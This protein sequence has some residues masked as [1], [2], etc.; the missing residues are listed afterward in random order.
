M[1][2]RNSVIAAMLAAG[3]VLSGVAGGESRLQISHAQE[4]EFIVD[5]DGV[6]YTV[7]GN[8]AT[9][10]VV[11]E[12]GS[13]DADNKLSNSSSTENTG[14]SDA[15]KKSSADNTTEDA[16]SNVASTGDTVEI[17]S[18]DDVADGESEQTPADAD[19]KEGSSSAGSNAGDTS[20]AETST[21]NYNVKV[22]NAGS[23]DETSDS[24]SAEDTSNVALDNSSAGGSSDEASDSSS[25]GDTSKNALPEAPTTTASADNSAS[26]ASSGDS[27]DS[28][29]SNASSGDS[30]Q[31][32][33]AEASSTESSA[34]NAAQ[35]DA[36]G[37]IEDGYEM[38]DP[39][40]SYDA[41]KP[42]VKLES[43]S[44]IKLY[45]GQPLV[46][47]MQVLLV[48]E[49]WLDGDGATYTFTESQTEIGSIPN[50]FK[51]KLNPGTPEDKYNIIVKYGELRVVENFN[52]Q[53]YILSIAGK[54]E[55][56]KYDGKKHTLKGFVLSARGNDEYR[57]EGK[58]EP[59]ETLS[60][61]IG[62]AT[63]TVSGINA[64]GSGTN[65]GDYVVDITGSPI[66]KDATGKDV[67][68]DFK[69]EYLP[70]TL[71]IEKRNITMKSVNAKK[72][73]DGEALTAH[74][75]K[76]SG[77]GFVDGEGA[78]YKFT[79]KQKDVGESFNYFTYTMNDGTLEANYNIKKVP[80]KLT[81]NEAKNS[82][83]EN[84][85]GNNSSE[86]NGN[87]EGGSS[88]SSSESSSGS[89]ESGSANAGST[90]PS[91]NSGAGVSAQ[92]GNTNANP[93]GPA[94]LGARK[95][96]DGEQDSKQDA[97]A[98]LGARKAATD[99]TSA[100]NAMRVLIM[101]LSSITVLYITGKN[102]RKNNG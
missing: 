64:E 19:N 43:M 48:E 97:P 71:T 38:A 27:S 51:I 37:D 35:T 77:D 17:P 75:V 9:D 86:E 21:D 91:D 16:A 30:T 60:F 102:K 12:A 74:E 57:V 20:S 66:V 31:N 32:S 25:A 88:G 34:D 58:G 79:G 1:R 83:G 80:G 18:S 55:S 8:N 54:T 52:D 36:S 67:T 69:F 101:L 41:T 15:D 44:Y 23:T 87:G 13:D 61:T 39:S 42:T 93:D 73:Y 76:V 95:S 53:K 99:D 85:S 70:G 56:V 10:D 6:S 96:R 100:D 45:D 49:G 7:K 98:V 90:T 82:G 2:I 89:S 50:K 92:A 40:D 65:A 59:E 24:S 33:A 47:D 29:A 84:S 46:D 22:S 68:N 72:D 94:V 78:T 26:N 4:A 14:E 81:V 62:N 3:L 5:E 63:Y 28:S 11:D